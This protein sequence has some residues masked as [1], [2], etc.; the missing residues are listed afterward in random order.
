MNIYSFQHHFHLQILEFLCP[1]RPSQYF[2]RRVKNETQAKKRVHP[3]D[4]VLNDYRTI[5]M[6]T[7]TTRM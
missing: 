2:N 6:Y 4:F 5:D 7:M 1:E 3:R